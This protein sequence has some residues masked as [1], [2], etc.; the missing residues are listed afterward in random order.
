[1]PRD[2]GSMCGVV[3]GLYAAIVTICSW[4]GPALAQPPRFF[5]P[6]I[7]DAEFREITSRLS[8]D[9][10]R[11]AAATGAF[12]R[13]LGAFEPKAGAMRSLA[14]R[15]DAAVRAGLP[16][17]RELTFEYKEAFGGFVVARHD[18]EKLLLAEIRSLLT[19]QELE[20]AWP[21][22]ERLRRRETLPLVQ[23]PAAT[24]WHRLDLVKLSAG[25]S[26]ADPDRAAIRPLL[27]QY[28]LDID[29][30]LLE[31]WR[32]WDQEMRWQK[33]RQERE[34][35]DLARRNSSLG[36]R[37]SDVNRRYARLLLQTLSPT[38]SSM[39][40]ALL[41]RGAYPEIAALPRPAFEVFENVL[42]LDDLAE[43]QR[44]QLDLVMAAYARDSAALDA[45]ARALYDRADDDMP[46]F[47]ELPEAEASQLINRRE[48]PASI[49]W[50]AVA[51]P[52]AELEQRTIDAV[53]A[54]LTPAQ[55]AALNLDRK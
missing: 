26:L 50:L 3:R 42:R 6:P 10:D 21:P 49:A 47:R 14:E 35:E 41:L 55:R 30:P 18:F 25:L 1:M 40:D 37:T 4:T 17:A 11:L 9:P 15:R 12:D 31:R 44:G 51:G 52:R 27:E 7:T 32:M 46:R 36:A 5:E 38:A 23:A 22:I 45:R 28:E 2:R 24:Y 16:T 13:A 8:L 33:E 34:S 20:E 53:R 19:Q 54:P 39:L 29:R 43:E 48:D